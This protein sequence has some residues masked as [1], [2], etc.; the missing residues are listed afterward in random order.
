MA[1]S[2]SA[3][4]RDRIQRQLT[5]LAGSATFSSAPQ[6]VSLLIY[7]VTSELDGTAHELN[8]ARIAMDVLGRSAAFDAT[9]DSVVRVEA[10]RLRSRLR[11]YYAAEGSDDEIRFEI[12]K[13]RYRPKIHLQAAPRSP[14]ASALQ[15]APESHGGSWDERLEA[16]RADL[17]A[18]CSAAAEVETLEGNIVGRTREVGELLSGLERACSGQ[19]QV[20]CVTGEPG[21]GKSTL[22]KQFLAQQRSRGLNCALAIGGCSERLAESEAYLPILEALES[23]LLGVW[24]PECGEL[25]KLVAPT[26]YVQVAPLWASAEPSFAGIVSDAKAASRERMKRELATFLEE[27]ARIMPVVLFLDDLHW[28]DAST[29]ELLAYLSRRLASAR[30]FMIVAYRSSEMM[31]ARHPFIALR[32]ELERQGLCRELPMGFLSQADIERYLRLEL[33]GQTLPAGFAGFI[34]SRTE[35]NPLFL[36][37]LIR[38][39][40]ERDK[41][42]TSLDSLERDLPDSVRSMIER[43]IGHLGE[44]EVALLATAAVQGY[45]FDSRIIADVLKLDAATVEERLRR[46]DRVHAFVRRL[47]DKELPDGSISVSYSFAHVLYQHAIEDT[48]TP[49]RKANLSKSTAEALLVRHKGHSAPLASRLA[50]LFEAA[51]DFEQSADYFITAAANAARLYA[52]EEAVLLSR[53]A[54]ANAE[55]LEGN[56][57]HTRVAAAASQ[58]GQLHMVLSRFEDAAAD[59]ECAENAAQA[60]GDVE[61]Q[62]NAICA[63]ALARFYLRK[64]DETREIASHALAVAQA[65]KSEIGIASAEAIRGLEQLCFGA[66][67]DAEESFQRSVPLLIKRTP[68][69]AA[70]EALTFSGLL[71]AWQLDYASSHRI[72]EWTMQQ[73]QDL[74]FSYHII[75]NLFVRGMTLFNEG[76]LSEGIRNLEE[77]MKLAEK[78]GERFWLSRFPNTLGWVYRELQDFDTALRFD[79]EGAKTA[80]ENGYAKPEAYSH[81]NLAQ[82]YMAAGEMTSV[83]EHLNRATELFGADVWFRWRYNIRAKA[84][85]ARY[86]LFQG[87]T[88]KARQYAAESIAIA[89][90]R[91]VRKHLAWAHKILGDVAMAEERMAD[92]RSEYEASMGLLDHHHCP[93]IEWRIL[94]SAADAASARHDSRSAD[95]YRGRCRQVIHGLAESL[96]EEKLRRQ[97][98][99]SEAIRQALA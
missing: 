35:G 21:I 54:V 14:A 66:V 33:P 60:A 16:A 53:R 30:L 93:L 73:A 58:Q 7:L 88:R 20:F 43:R 65:G 98:I 22:V 76:R 27:M 8:Q 6:L 69:P 3:P 83:L 29:A 1:S 75:L 9:S 96:T 50:V 95:E 2:Y 97:F 67:D 56:A 41:F 11:D 51:R 26:W 37:E 23:L 4:E 72:T 78:N 18:K 10:G 45:E 5:E 99:N 91:R 71:R 38:H 85:L 89:E 42:G 84:E 61:A 82:D 47:H 80:R 77:G 70:L 52:N 49:S 79:A 86:W 12:P 87:D 64:M 34:H 15:V 36:T 62:V 63:R 39:L 48:L 19:I 57:Y 90:P 40:R 92:A 32:Q 28:G 31:L 17:S 46:L 94:Q 74:G 59:F 68:P 13:G 55:K 24:G 81:V 25:M 44:D